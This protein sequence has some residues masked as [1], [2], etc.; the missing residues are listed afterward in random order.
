MRGGRERRERSE[1]EGERGWRERGGE[2]RRE[3]REIKREW[4]IREG[5]ES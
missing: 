3:R 4:A 1:P 2:E 5:E